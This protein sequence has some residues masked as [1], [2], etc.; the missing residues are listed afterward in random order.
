VTEAAKKL[1]AGFVKLAKKAYKA[2][3]ALFSGI[4]TTVKMRVPPVGYLST[5][6]EG[7]PI[8][9][10]YGALLFKKV[11]NEEKGQEI[12]F[13]CV[14]CFFNSTFQMGGKIKLSLSEGFAGVVATLDGPMELHFNVAVVA[15]QGGEIKD[16]KQI[17]S[18][19]L[20]GVA[21]GEL[22]EI[23]LTLDFSVGYE[24]SLKAEVTFL[25]NMTLK[26][27]AFHGQIDMLFLAASKVKGLVPNHFTPAFEFQGDYTLSAGVFI[28]AALNIGIS[29]LDGKHKLNV[30]IN[31]K[32]TLEASLSEQYGFVAN[33]EGFSPLDCEGYD[34]AIKLKNDVYLSAD[35]ITSLQLELNHIET[36]LWET[37]LGLSHT[38]SEAESSTT[39]SSTPPSTVVPTV[40]AVT[41]PNIQVT[42]TPPTPS[43]QIPI[44]TTT[45]NNVAPIATCQPGTFQNYGNV[46]EHNMGFNFLR[47]WN[48]ACPGCPVVNDRSKITYQTLYNVPDIATCCNF[49]HA[50]PGGCVL[51]F[52]EPNYTTDPNSGQEYIAPGFTCSAV[53]QT[54]VSDG[55][56]PLP[57]P[58]PSICPYGGIQAK[59]Y[60]PGQGNLNNIGG[61]SGELGICASS[62]YVGSP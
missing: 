52:I 19:P 27:D 36:A 54:G 45:A 41:T 6:E 57:L 58:W 44:P 46:L 11:I 16:S 40:A 22:G 17:I 62:N 29:I 1:G 38:D 34:L 9:G 8:D 33:G 2:A 23:G 26:W 31:E 28:N 13:F 32:P 60:G 53:I 25:Q 35:V 55:G 50:Q 4:S 10:L 47:G 12:K 14:G 3:K 59:G 18:V 48:P 37:C 24:L 61:F 43:P 30:G 56:A 20:I 7:I 5:V 15:E 51:Y 39:S 42:S 49:C 21:L